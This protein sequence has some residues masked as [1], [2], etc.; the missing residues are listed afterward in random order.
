[1]LSIGTH[2]GDSWEAALLV[3]NRGNRS[4]NAFLTVEFDNMT[5]VGASIEI[6]PGGVGDLRVMANLG[7]GVHVGDWSVGST[8]GLVDGGLNGTLTADVL[9]PQRVTTMLTMDAWSPDRTTGDIWID[10]S[11]GASR[12]VSM[13]IEFL[14]VDGP[15]R[16]CSE[17][18][19]LLDAGRRHL[20]VDLPAIWEQG[21]MRASVIPSWTTAPESILQMTAS[22]D[23]ARPIA[24]I[25]QTTVQA[26]EPMADDL[27]E[28]TM[29]L[30]NRGESLLPAGSITIHDGLRRPLGIVPTP[31]MGVGSTN[32]V[33][34]D[35]TWPPEQLVT[36]DL[37]WMV[38][39]I[40][41]IEEVSVTSG[42]VEPSE[43]TQSGVNGRSVIA[44]VGVG[45]GVLMLMMIIRV[46]RAA[47]PNPV[48]NRQGH[49]EETDPSSQ[50]ETIPPNVE[51]GCPECAQ[52][53]R[54]PGTYQ[55]RI[56]CPAC[57][58]RFQVDSKEQPNTAP[59]VVE[60]SSSKEAQVTTTTTAEEP[61]AS[62]SSDVI[63]CPS[64]TARLK[65][66]LERRPTRA[67]CPACRTEFRALESKDS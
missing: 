13:I 12:E 56:R 48:V 5:H 36:L 41:V 35:I 10:L 42:A 52:I 26:A 6:P 64:C 18:I 40:E 58:H 63:A 66:P 61:E 50:P 22:L 3:M 46:W 29:V 32:E 55:G 45:L 16:R 9:S 19:L 15:V 49:D 51:V 14:P 4:G 24:T 21:D 11:E 8:D 44:G 34:L 54:V 23:D 39:E 38:G 47:A 37:L 62:S 17:Q 30:S 60:R 31:E 59:D 2:E 57:D 67:R 43:S 28:V 25:D 1:M 33:T 27:V 65:V 20:D 7:A 53:L